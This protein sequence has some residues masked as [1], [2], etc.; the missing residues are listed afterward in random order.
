MYLFDLSVMATIDRQNHTDF[1]EYLML[2]GLV[3]SKSY[4]VE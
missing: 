4:F 1:V 2:F 3:N